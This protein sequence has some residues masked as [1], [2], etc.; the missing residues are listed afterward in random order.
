MLG[1]I[2]PVWQLKAGWMEAEALKL[3]L[4]NGKGFSLL[5]AGLRSHNKTAW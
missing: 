2:I 5:A 3:L 4:R 1:I